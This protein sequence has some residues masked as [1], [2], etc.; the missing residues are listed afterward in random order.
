MFEDK[1][2]LSQLSR[3]SFIEYLNNNKFDEIVDKVI[4]PVRITTEY[5]IKA[6][7]RKVEDF[8]SAPLPGL[9]TVNETWP[10][11]LPDTFLG[12]LKLPYGILTKIKRPRRKRLQ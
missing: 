11:Y 1:M 6:Q 2:Y 4:N 5:S 7:E 9:D 10:S 8:H 12:Y 3:S